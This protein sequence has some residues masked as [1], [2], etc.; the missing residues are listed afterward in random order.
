MKEDKRR[1]DR[2]R[3]PL[4]RLCGTDL[5]IPEGSGVEALDS[6]GRASYWDDVKDSSPEEDEVGA[7]EERAVC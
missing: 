3:L 1:S 4:S 7:D 2:R 6:G 5:G